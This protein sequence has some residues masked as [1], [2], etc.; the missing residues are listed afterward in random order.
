[1][2]L[3]LKKIMIKGKDK[4]KLK[5][6]ILIPILVTATVVY[7]ASHVASDVKV[8]AD[9]SLQASIYNSYDNENKTDEVKEEIEK[10]IVS[11]IYVDVGGAVN[12]PKVVCIPEG[13]RVFE[14]VASAGGISDNAEI[15]YINMAA[16]CTDGEKIYIPTEKEIEEN[17]GQLLSEGDSVYTANNTLSCENSGTVNINTAGSSELQ[18][19]SGIGPSMAERILEYRTQNGKFSSI[20]DLKKVSG[21]GD[22]KFGELKEH[23]CV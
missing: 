8:N 20:E 17:K 1:M 21:I 18:T 4:T 5:W 16:V 3:R 10:E 15:K 11:D 7:Y 6:F 23:I 14:A 22:K 9:P 13:S 2:R 12:E 19:L